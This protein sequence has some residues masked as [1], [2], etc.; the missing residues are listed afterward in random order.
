MWKVGILGAG[1]ISDWHLKA[2]RSIANVHVVAVCDLNRSRAES[3]AGRHGIANAF[4]S[5]DEMVKNS[6]C[7]AV[8]V[9]LPPE[10]HFVAASQLLDAGVHVLLEKPACISLSECDQ[11]IELAH[12]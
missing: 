8:H 3:F 2:L 1:Y 10:L 12:R 6:Q 5:I 7:A 11:L 4:T 9:L